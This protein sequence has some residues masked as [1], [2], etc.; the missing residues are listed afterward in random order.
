M[1]QRPGIELLTALPDDPDN[2]VRVA[3]CWKYPP[4]IFP[5]LKCDG[6]GRHSTLDVAKDTLKKN[7][8]QY[9]FFF[10]LNHDQVAHDN[11]KT[12]CEQFHVGSIFF[13]SDYTFPLSMSTFD[14]LLAVIL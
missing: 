6:T 4:S 9:L 1:L 3:D 5:S 7:L 2:L 14:T 11:P 8:Q 10:F 12:C 13:L